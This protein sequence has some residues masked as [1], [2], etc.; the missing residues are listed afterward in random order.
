MCSLSALINLMTR[1][2]SRYMRLC[3]GFMSINKI[4]SAT[5]YVRYRCTPLFNPYSRMQQVTYI[6]LVSYWSDQIQ[7]DELEGTLLSMYS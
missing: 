4:T 3:V 7:S 5:M 2:E 1:H 6:L